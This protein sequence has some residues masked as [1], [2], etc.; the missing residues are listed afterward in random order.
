MALTIGKVNGGIK[1][2]DEE[3]DFSFFESAL[4]MAKKPHPFKI[5]VYGK[6]SSGKTHFALSAPAPV[7]VLDS[8]NR[9]AIISGKFSNEKGTQK[10]IFSKQWTT[11]EELDKATDEAIKVLKNHAKKTGIIGT[12]A[13]D[14]ISREWEEITQSYVREKFGDDAKVSDVKLDPMHDYKF[15]NEKH[16]K[17][18]QKIL[19]SGMNIIFTATAKNDYNEDRYNPSGVKPE[20]QKHLSHA[21]D[22]TIFNYSKDNTIFSQI[23]KNSL[24]LRE[25]DDVQMMDFEKFKKLIG[26]LKT[27]AKIR[28]F[29]EIEAEI[30]KIEEMEA[31]EAEANNDNT[32]KVNE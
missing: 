19:D 2:K 15:L 1:A 3:P 5:L 7:I 27:H 28:T 10:G 20:G 11:F 4:D 30:K 32:E 22:Y 6:P 24:I 8:E 12:I 29:E 21:V 9:A 31:K 14:S 26:T 23:Q 17:W 13:I 16:N 25:L 18:M